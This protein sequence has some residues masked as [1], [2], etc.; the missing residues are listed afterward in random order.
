[1]AAPEATRGLGGGDRM[2]IESTSY[3][4]TLPMIPSRKGRG[5]E[6][7]DPPQADKPRP[8]GRSPTKKVAAGFIPAWKWAKSQ[9]I[10]QFKR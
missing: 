7:L 4:I 9:K 8:Y 1:M 5:N 2:E 10:A 3:L 6:L